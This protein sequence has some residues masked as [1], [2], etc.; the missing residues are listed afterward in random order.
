MCIKGGLFAC[1]MLLFLLN[2]AAATQQPAA[3]PDSDWG[4]YRKDQAGTGYSPL[5]Q[6]DTRNVASLS[7]A[8][9][10]S[11]QSDAPP[12]ANARG[13]GGA[14]GPNSEATPIVISGVM[15]LP[16]ANRVVALESETGKEIWSYSLTA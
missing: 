5:S 13:R 6:I 14:G 12:A 11:L 4:M 15:Y 1:A 9:T 7:Q 8:W 16:T 3:A 10:F 2:P